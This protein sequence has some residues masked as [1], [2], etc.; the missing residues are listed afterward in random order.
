[1]RNEVLAFMGCRPQQSWPFMASAAQGS[2]VTPASLLTACRR[3]QLSLQEL[4]GIALPSWGFEYNF[5]DWETFHT[6]LYPM[7]QD[8][9]DGDLVSYWS[10]THGA[11]LEAIVVAR[12]VT[13]SGSVFSYD[14][15]VKQ[16]AL[17]GR[18]RRRLQH[19]RRPPK[20]PVDDSPTLLGEAC[21]INFMGPDGLGYH[22]A[23]W[24]ALLD[25]TIV[26]RLMTDRHP[27]MAPGPDSTFAEGLLRGI[28]RVPW[29]P[30]DDWLF[31][32][33]CR[34]RMVFL[35]WVGHALGLQQVWA[36]IVLPLVGWTDALPHHGPPLSAADE[37]PGLLDQPWVLDEEVS[38]GSE[39]SQLF[40]ESPERREEAAAIEGTADAAAAAPATASAAPVRPEAR[41]A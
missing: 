6:F 23:R 13:T 4:E 18:I 30:S 21:C 19:S 29:S 41:R 27:T 11:W 37:G 17:P 16:G 2:H 1:V 24:A 5:R 34:R 28:R 31:P 33:H 25:G 8:F 38:E 40:S 7:L 26:A 39:E 3:W 15:D 9:M 20:F 10:K 36:R 22:S 32:W 35:A 12:H 14:L